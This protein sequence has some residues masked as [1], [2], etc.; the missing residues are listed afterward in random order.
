MLY[1]IN[2]NNVVLDF[3]SHCEEYVI[4]TT[5]RELALL[6]KYHVF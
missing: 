3:L 5:F 6:Q 2:Y 4:H 1:V